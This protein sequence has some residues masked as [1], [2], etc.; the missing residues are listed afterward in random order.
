MREHLLGQSAPLAVVKRFVKAQDTPA[1]LQAVSRH[2]QLVHGVNVLYVQ[3]DARSV[4]RLGRPHIKILVP[5]S[6]EVES[7]I[8]VIEVRK[9]RKQV[10]MT[11]GVQLGICVNHEHLSL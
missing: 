10:Q 6:F 2:F 5:T 9:F 7:I 1:S 8:A 4:R 11:F 3:L